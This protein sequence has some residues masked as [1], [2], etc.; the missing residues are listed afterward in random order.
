MGDRR[1]DL[2]GNSSDD[3]GT[4]RLEAA[5]DGDDVSSRNACEVTGG[6][7]SLSDDESDEQA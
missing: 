3:A 2:L 7:T 4:L 1:H 5:S 6:I